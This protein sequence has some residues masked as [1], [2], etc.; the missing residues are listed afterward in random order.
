MSTRPSSAS[1]ASAMR[2]GAPSSMT[3]C[4]MTTGRNSFDDAASISSASVSSSSRRRATIASLTPSAA[5]PR[6]IARPM[7]MLA[8]VTRAVLSLSCRSIASSQTVPYRPD[9]GSMLDRRGWRKFAGQCRNAPGPFDVFMRAVYER[10][11]ISHKET[12]M[13]K[14]KTFLWFDKEAEEAANYYVSVFKNGKVTNVGRVTMDEESAKASGGSVGEQ[15]L[16]AD[17]ELFGQEYIALNGG[18]AFNFTEAISLMVL[19]DSQEEV[20]AYWNR[21]VGDGGEESQCGWCK[22]KYGLSWQITP[23]RLLDCIG[24][25]D[26]EAA[27]RAMH[28]MLKMQKIDV[29]AIKKAYDGA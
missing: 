15:V 22:D 6:A 14:I 27:G 8:P 21:L 3:S 1:A 5:S 20:D 26:K 13:Q 7:P 23:Q 18:P 28:A 9:V 17:F 25:S 4:S 19:C 10:S 16:T 29:A 11:A 2:C 12:P 24:S